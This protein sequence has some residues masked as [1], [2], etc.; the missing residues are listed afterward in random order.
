MFKRHSLPLASLV[1][2]SLLSAC[3]TQTENDLGR[4]PEPRYEQVDKNLE[5]AKKS[6]GE[7]AI[8]LYLSAVDKA[9]QAGDNIQARS[10]L[11]AAVLT[12]A[13]PAQ[14]MFAHTLAAEMAIAR[15]QPE[16]ALE[17]LN[18]ED[19]ARISELPIA[20]QARTQLA[21]AAALESLG[22]LMAAARERIFTAPYLSDEA[23][24]SNHEAIWDLITR[25]PS[26][27][28]QVQNEIDLDGWL[29]LASIAAN[30]S[31]LADKQQQIRNWQANNPEHPAAIVPPA[32]LQHLM[33]LQPLQIKRIAVLLPSQD[34]NQNVVDAI[35]NGML[36]AYYHAS[37]SSQQVPQLYFYDSN[38]ITSFGDLYTDLKRNRIDLLIGPWEK[39]KVNK[40]DQ[41]QALPIP[42]L[43]LNYSERAGDRVTGSL[44]QFGLAAEDEA[45]IAARQAWQDG[46]RNAVIL[47]QSGDWGQ[48]IAAAFSRYWQE[49]GGT[50]SGTT[51]LGQPIELTQ[52]IGNL[53][54]LR[55]SE[56]RGR[57]LQNT[58]G[59]KINTHLSRRRDVDFIFLAAPAQQARQVKPTLRFQYAGD[60]P[61]YATSAVNLSHGGA[62]MQE[63]DGIMLS[64][65]PWLLGFDS[66]LRQEII[67]R[68]PDAA[69]VMG[70]FYALGADTYQL[71]QQL[72]QLQALPN[73]KTQGLTGSLQ[74]NARQ[75]IE[76]GLHWAVISDG[77]VMPVIDNGTN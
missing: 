21:R 48:R 57:R 63:L 35:R 55:E 16:L 56:A 19:F 2:F 50:V 62:Q 41:Q 26:S 74:M 49:L 13:T 22:R 25:L 65:I 15:Q 1:F 20:Q 11:D 14:L 36:S 40:L 71:A 72:Q 73:N 46:K 54:Q 66:Q 51:S 37:N 27:H 76:R 69:G 68:W 31:S 44:Y 32:Q 17:I 8:G 59:L 6:R 10:L 34:P 9:W 18:N 43:A 39:D 47:V 45:R 60:L 61:I 38:Q 70:R 64:E 7:A 3:A 23:A 77:K 28:Y 30:Q 29:E 67:R 12:E 4:L 53:L 52:Q 5:L 33:Q 42:T 75:Q 58:L 24:I